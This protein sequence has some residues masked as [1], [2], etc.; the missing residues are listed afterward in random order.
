M[1]LYV[2]KA[3]SA[4]APTIVFLHGSGVSSWMWNEQ[5]TALQG[6]YQCI[7]IDLPGNGESYQTEWVSFAD[8]ADQ[9]ASIIRQSSVNGK[10]HVVGL[11][12][13]GYTGLVLLQNHA[14][15]VESLIVSGV[16]AKPFS[17][18]WRWR[19]LLGIMQPLMKWD[20]FINLQAKMLHI[21][22]EAAALYKRDNKR[23]S[24]NGF[25]RIYN[26]VLHFVLP[27]YTDQQNIRLLAVAGDGENL[28]IKDSL[29]DF[30]NHKQ[31]TVAAS[32][33]NAHHGWTGEH[34]QLFTDMVKAWVQQ[35]PLPADLILFSA[36]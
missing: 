12:L 20:V 14:D 34:P 36:D 10:A 19:I 23:M 31:N 24:S 22:P 26:E 11:S 28:M 4:T 15:V 13:G 6:E 2:H 25:H 30:A 35:K 5:I 21:P 1:S 8:T 18:I 29:K 16:S 3:G 7:A 33:P 9:V 27:A 32:V 17:N